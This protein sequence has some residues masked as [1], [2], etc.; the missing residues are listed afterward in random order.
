MMLVRFLILPVVYGLFMVGVASASAATYD[1]YGCEE[2]VREALPPLGYTL[3]GPAS[4]RISENCEKGPT[5]L[6]PSSAQIAPGGVAGIT[7]RVPAPLAIAAYRSRVLSRAHRSVY[8]N[9]EYWWQIETRRTVVGGPSYLTGTCSGRD[10]ACEEQ[11]FRTPWTEQRPH[12]EQMDW[13]LR[14]APDSPG[15]CSAGSLDGIEL[16]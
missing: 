2:E 3:N 12:S 14:C 10:F 1:V 9:P 5:S 13:M 11:Y 4:F 6:V 15:W 7:L 8:S 16:L